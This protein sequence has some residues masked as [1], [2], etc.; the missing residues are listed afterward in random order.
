MNASL[1]G[2]QFGGE[3]DGTPGLLG[4][5]RETGSS[6]G[7]LIT[8]TRQAGCMRVTQKNPDSTDPEWPPRQSA[9]SPAK[10]PGDPYPLMRPR[11]HTDTGSAA[12]HTGGRGGHVSS[13]LCTVIVSQDTAS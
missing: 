2:L 4:T 11:L 8:K 7:K 13:Q 3:R 12:P 9:D 5:T 1:T 6:S 10:H